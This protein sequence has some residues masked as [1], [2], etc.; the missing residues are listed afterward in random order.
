MGEPQ[1]CTMRMTLPFLLFITLMSCSDESSQPLG[2]DNAPCPEEWQLSTYTSNQSNVV[3]K[4]INDS[5]TQQLIDG[6]VWFE[7]IN[8]QKLESGKFRCYIRDYRMDGVMA[9]EG[10]AEYEES[11]VVEYS[12]EGQWKFYNCDGQLREVVDFEKGTREEVIP[13]P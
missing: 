12:S 2:S 10:Y 8:P 5:T 9:A 6:K 4:Q 3:E 1:H 7:M 13:F 11:P